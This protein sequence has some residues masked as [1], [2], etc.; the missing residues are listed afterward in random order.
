MLIRTTSNSE[1]HQITSE[2]RISRLITSSAAPKARSMQ[3][4]NHAIAEHLMA[5]PVVPFHPHLLHLGSQISSEMSHGR[6]DS[7]SQETRSAATVFWRETPSLDE[8]CCKRTESAIYFGPSRSSKI[9]RAMILTPMI[10][11]EVTSDHGINRPPVSPRRR[12]WKQN[13]GHTFLRSPTLH[14]RGGQHRVEEVVWRSCFPHDHQQLY[15]LTMLLALRS[16]ISDTHTGSRPLYTNQWVAAA[17]VWFHSETNVSEKKTGSVIPEKSQASLREP[18]KRPTSF[19]NNFNSK[20]N[21]SYCRRP[22]LIA[23][24]R[25]TR[26]VHLARLLHIAERCND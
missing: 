14:A 15:T 7:R 8:L 1:A 18:C 6:R 4:K 22:D 25:S 24:E 11:F 19:T 3:N 20:G 23:G 26:N 16:F 21:V 5:P 2:A 10:P 12:F 17:A 13:S 9:P